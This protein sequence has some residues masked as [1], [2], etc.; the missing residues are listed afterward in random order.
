MIGPF[1]GQPIGHAFLPC[2]ATEYRLHG[3]PLKAILLLDAVN[4]RARAA[5]LPGFHP[6][7][8]RTGIFAAGQLTARRSGQGWLVVEQGSGVAERILLVRHLTACTRP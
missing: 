8:G 6:V 7:R 5:A 2:I 4:P 1:A 3:R